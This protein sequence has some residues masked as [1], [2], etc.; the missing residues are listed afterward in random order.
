VVFV[1]V[2]LVEQEKSGGKG[3]LFG[4]FGRRPAQ[5]L[6]SESPRFERKQSLPVRVS[7]LVFSACLQ[8]PV[9]RALS[10]CLPVVDA[11]KARRLGR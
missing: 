6:A 11:T 3:V 9:K 2:G 5:K 1:V 4:S 7:C 8:W 10:A